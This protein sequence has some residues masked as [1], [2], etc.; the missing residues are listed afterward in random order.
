MW[1]FIT[2]L[3]IHT[4]KVQKERKFLFSFLLTFVEICIFPFYIFEIAW[5]SMIFGGYVK[6]LC[7]VSSRSQ[8]VI[9]SQIITRLTIIAVTIKMNFYF[10]KLW[11]LGKSHYATLLW[12]HCVITMSIF[13]VTCGKINSTK[14]GRIIFNVRISHVK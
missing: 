9:T 6:A 14:M 1:V 8:V 2:K 12:S 10:V 13:W 7:V 11:M 4:K 5:N 3:Q